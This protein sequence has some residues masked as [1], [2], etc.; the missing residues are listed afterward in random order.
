MSDYI[1]PEEKLLRLIRG[2][3]QSQAREIKPLADNNIIVA[4]TKNK[5]KLTQP[6]MLKKYFPV[7]NLK[8]TLSWLFLVTVICLAITFAY[9]WFGL[10]KIR[11]PQLKETKPET[12]IAELKQKIKSYDYYLQGIR[13]RQIFAS[14][15][16]SPG[17]E[18]PVSPLNADILKDISLVGIISGDN[19]QAIIE[20]KKT[21]QTLY[22]TK[23]QYIGEIQVEDIQEGKIII[24]Y[25]NARYE[26]YL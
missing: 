6:L 19:P 15:S 23:G 16:S 18:K 5:P 12:Q 24:N 20:D 3:K 26:L 22:V 9:P 14:M 11:L 17:L 25:Q 1:S 2:K 21:Q 8:K 7:F 4:D 10:K 13:N